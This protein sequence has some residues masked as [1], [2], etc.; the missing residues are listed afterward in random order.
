MIPKT[1]SHL[2]ASFE[3]LADWQYY[4]VIIDNTEILTTRGI[5]LRMIA[6]SAASH[7]KVSFACSRK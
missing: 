1:K 5:D 4:Q 3:H 7:E 6:W 2:I